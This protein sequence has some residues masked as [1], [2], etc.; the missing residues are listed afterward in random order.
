M[1]AVLVAWPSAAVAQA[2]DDGGAVGP[3]DAARDGEPVRVSCGEAPT[4][5]LVLCEAYE[6]IVSR[7]VDG[8]DDE[9][10]ASAAARGVREAGLEPRVG[11]ASEACALPAAAFEQ[12]CAEIEAVAD[13]SA[14]VWAAA[15]TMLVSLGDR[16]SMLLTADQHEAFVAG[17]EGG[18]PF[19]GIGLKL[20]LLDGVLPCGSVSATCRLVI[21]EVIPDSP[22]ERAGLRADDILVA[23]DGLVPAGAGCGLNELRRFQPGTPVTVTVDRDG[24]EMVF[25]MEAAL[26]D[27]PVSAGR[28]VDGDI[29]YL[30]LDSFSAS[31]DVL[32]GAQLQRLLDD[33]AGSLVLDL[34]DNPGG[35][36]TTV[37][38]IASLFLNDQAVVTREVTRFEALRHL[39]DK[40][41]GVP[42]PAVLPMV[43]AVDGS[44]ASASELLTLALRDHGRATVV[45]STT[46][47]KNTGQITQAVESEDGTVLGAVRL[48]VLR[49]LSPDGTSAAGGIE[50]DVAVR[51]AQ[52]GHPV[53]MARQAVAAAGLEG[54][55]PAD[56]GQTGERFDA[57]EAL[58]GDGVLERTECEPGLFCPDEPVTRAVLAV[59]LVRVLDGADP[60]PDALGSFEDV[61]ASLWWAAHVERL[62]DLGVT[63]GCRREPAR[64]CPRQTVTR[65]QAA[66]LLRR[67]FDLE[68]ALPAGFADISERSVAADASALYAAGITAGCSREPRLFCPDRPTSRGEMAVLLQRARAHQWNR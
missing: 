15:E 6:L 51:F 1:L 25:A 48:T 41:Q 67:A 53:G 38:D 26:V 24:R 12:V 36:L 52:C 46:Y 29:G 17:L 18:V 16:Q 59:W 39:A 37:V 44:S 43:V 20:G 22:A 30:R 10:L 61:D 56:I 35:Y 14:A 23:L 65:A 45:G 9:D 32:L 11:E 3:D 8:A 40:H 21:S 68:A 63:L 47:G 13:V 57:V 42:D 27:L 49:W 5:Y 31:A 34:R 33:G 58:R 2:P 64:F 28:I 19:A 62:A 7:H 66:V 54:A 60:A 50:P 55:E 4:V